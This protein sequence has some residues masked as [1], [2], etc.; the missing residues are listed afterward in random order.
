M[1]LSICRPGQTVGG[2]RAKAQGIQSSMYGSWW[3]LSPKLGGERFL[4]GQSSGFWCNVWI[5]VVWEGVGRFTQSWQVRLLL[6]T[7]WD[8]YH[9]MWND[10]RAG[11]LAAKG[12]RFLLFAYNACN[13]CFGPW[14]THANFDTK[15]AWFSAWLSSSC[16]S[17]Q[18]FLENL[19]EL[20]HD[21]G[22][23]VPV[24]EASVKDFFESLKECPSLSAIGAQPRMM[25]WFSLNTSI[26]FFVARFH[27]EST[28]ILVLP[29]SLLR[30]GCGP[31]GRASCNDRRSRCQS[32]L[33]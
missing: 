29:Q 5:S 33:L 6:F 1:D 8:L 22:I 20:A 30:R 17:S 25:S 18:W 12:Q 19:Q 15:K 16:A 2:T 27:A 31:I 13:A 10:I 14:N 7:V 9:R 4:L 3:T 23:P 26:K 11:V 21:R 32:A 24:G 28:R